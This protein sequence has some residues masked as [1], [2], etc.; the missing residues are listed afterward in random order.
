MVDEVSPVKVAA[1]LSI[2]VLSIH[3]AEN[4]YRDRPHVNSPLF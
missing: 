4:H 1:H 3:G 2:P